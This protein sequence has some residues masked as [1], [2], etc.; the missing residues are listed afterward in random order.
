VRPACWAPAQ[1]RQHAGSSRVQRGACEAS[2]V[3]RM[4]VM[5][6]VPSRV[7]VAARHWFVKGEDTMLTCGRRRRT[8]GALS[9]DLAEERCAMRTNTTGNHFKAPIDRAWLITKVG[10]CPARRHRH[11][12]LSVH[13]KVVLITR[14]FDVIIRT[15]Q[16]VGIARYGL[17]V[18]WVLHH[19]RA[20][21]DGSV[22]CYR[23]LGL[24]RPT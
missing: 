13:I 15:E 8:C 11:E 19:Q 10:A 1:W 2:E 9:A 20:A 16:P 4:P 12:L 18:H 6:T 24:S 23:L 14:H 17:Q 3:L 22:G 21:G 7:H 5:S